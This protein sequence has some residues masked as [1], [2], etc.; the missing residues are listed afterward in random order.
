MVQLDFL[1]YLATQLVKS[2][3]NPVFRNSFEDPQIAK[4]DFGDDFVWGVGTSA[5]QI[6]GAWNVD[7][8]GE[9]IWD[10]STSKKW[11]VKDRSNGKEAID[12]YNRSESDL[13]LLKSL[14][15]ENFRFSFSWSRILPEGTVSIN[16][17]GVDFYNR[18]IDSCLELG[19]E[20][21]AMLYHWDLPQKL[22]DRGG[23]TNRDMVGWFSEYTDLCTRRFGDRI[24]HWMVLNEPS[25]FTLL[26]YLAGIHAPN[27][28]NVNKFLSS[29]HHACLCQAEGGRIIRNNV[30]NSHIGTT[31]SCSAV[32]PSKPL[33]SHQ[34]A[35]QRVD[36]LLNRLF[37]E[38]SLGMGYPLEDL[39]FLKK[40]EKYIQ[41]GDHDKLKFDFDFIGIQN[42]FRVVCKPSL[43]P[44]V[45]ANRVPPEKQAEMTEMGWEVY[46]EGIYNILMQFSKYPV[47][48][49]I[50][51][52]NGAAFSD[53]LIGG[54]V[55]DQQRISFYKRY[56]YNI[57]KAK[58][59]GVNIK[60]YFAW[61]LIDNFEWI[62]GFR[63]RFGMVYNDF[64]TQQRTVK[65]SGLW[66][67][68]FL[69]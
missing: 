32:V 2:K 24:R 29:V 21:W 63:P 4:I 54:Q 23:W 65:D 50:I 18:L 69:S 67:R 39:S 13:K 64:K 58:N 7:G 1:K 40:I 36:V 27:Q 5:Y 47:K 66:F 30:K 46:P 26:G 20:P 37:I 42:Y 60:G 14:N 12:F 35:A 56:L 16:E 17:K 51:T 34:N 61:T 28:S 38:P 3:A 43:I 57:L 52:E 44:Y 33:K 59:E 10:R 68:D 41:P 8:K 62:E 22:E 48:E 15:F 11:S 9:S 45:R 25:G 19:L 53:Q 49:I 6:E 31:F 55:H